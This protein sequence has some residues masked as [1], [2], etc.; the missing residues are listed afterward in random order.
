MFESMTA[1]ENVCKYGEPGDKFYIIIKGLCGMQ[2]PN[3]KI[4]DWRSQS[5]R[6]KMLQEWVDS[7][8]PEYE[9]RKAELDAEDKGMV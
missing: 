8:R 3:P 6:H 9:I 2:I 1:N 4:K 5:F 7:L